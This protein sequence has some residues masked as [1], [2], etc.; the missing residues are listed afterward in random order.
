MRVVF[1]ADDFGLSRGVN[2]G[3]A[4]ACVRGVLRSTSLMVTA[5]AAEDAVAIARATPGLDVGL[6]LTLVE[7]R[8][9][10]PAARIPTLLRDGRLLPSHAAVALRWITGH[11]RAAEARE[12]LAAQWARADA[13][14]IVPSHVDG[15]Q[16]LHLLPDVLP[17]VVAEARR[18]GIRFVRADLYEPS[19]RGAGLVRVASYAALR[20]IAW[21]ARRAAGT[22]GLHPFWTVGFLRAGGALDRDGL[23]TLLDRVRARAAPDVVEVMLH[24]G[25]RDADTVRRYGHWRYAWERDLDLLLD[26][27]LPEAL[28]A[29]GIAVT[30]FGA[31]AAQAPSAAEGAH[32]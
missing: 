14:G 21:R 12:E 30:S 16:H 7:E 6:H 29:R 8:P 27:R 22:T 28:V 18:R 24:P 19:D 1:H 20:G 32:G 15:H 23:L 13:L 25:Q 17:S 10:A 11:W 5:D 4:E 2:A 31:L 9:A 3:I 26:P